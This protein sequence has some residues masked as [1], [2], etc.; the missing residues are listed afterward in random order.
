MQLYL[1]RP[2]AAFEQLSVRRCPARRLCRVLVLSL[3]CCACRWL[4]CSIEKS[5]GV[6][7]AGAARARL[8]S[9][10]SSREQRRAESGLVPMPVPVPISV[11]RVSVFVSALVRGSA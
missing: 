8:V 10:A 7:E 3:V 6:D 2:S 9:R 5:H 1:L 11:V 4:Y